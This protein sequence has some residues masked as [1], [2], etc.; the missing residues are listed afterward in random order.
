MA[1]LRQQFVLEELQRVLT[2]KLGCSRRLAV[3]SQRRILRRAQRVEPGASRHEVP[4][5]PADTP[6]LRAAL[7][8]GADYLVTNDTHLLAL[9]PYEGLHILSMTD[10]HQVLVAEG[11][12]S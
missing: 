11:F 4:G 6:V 7:A 8:A 12:L 10:Y 3:L 2:E 5:D 9:D 1:D